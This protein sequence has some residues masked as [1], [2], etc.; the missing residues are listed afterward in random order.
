MIKL[1]NIFTDVQATSTDEVFAF[2]GNAMSELNIAN[3]EDIVKA[4]N[5]RESEGTTAFVN[6]IAIPHGKLNIDAPVV[7]IIKFANPISAWESMDGNPVEV[8]INIL[9]P[10]NGNNEHLAI[11]SNLSRKLV[12]EEFT[13]M[14]K[15]VEKTDAFLANFDFLK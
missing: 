4:L 14:I 2:I 7:N 5:H 11:L 8:A 1:E 12:S 6:G 9:V 3:Q 13:T 15:N 10:E